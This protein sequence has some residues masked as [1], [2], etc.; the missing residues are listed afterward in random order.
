MPSGTTQLAELPSLVLISQPQLAY[1][2]ALKYKSQIKPLI[3][4]STSKGTNLT[5]SNELPQRLGMSTNVASPN[6]TDGP[7]TD[8]LK[9]L[10]VM[11]MFF[12]RRKKIDMDIHDIMYQGSNNFLT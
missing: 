8:L 9:E 5:C 6:N 11:I 12:I 7:L 10:V 1:A 4:A 2:F 3:P